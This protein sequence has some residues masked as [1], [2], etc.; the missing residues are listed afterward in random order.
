MGD[1]EQTWS[2]LVPNLKTRVMNL[3]D[4]DTTHASVE[5]FIDSSQVRLFCQ[6]AVDCQKT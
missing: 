6:L 1:E 2:K 4:K 3:S 5:N